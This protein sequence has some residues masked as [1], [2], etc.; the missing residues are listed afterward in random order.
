MTHSAGDPFSSDSFANDSQRGSVC[1]GVSAR[2]LPTQRGVS[3]QMGVYAQGVSAQRECLSRH[4]L[5]IIGQQTPPPP[6]PQDGHCHSRCASHPMQSCIFPTFIIKVNFQS[7]RIRFF[8][9]LKKKLPVA[10]KF[11][12]KLI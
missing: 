10:C 3:A 1:L 9:T 12:L 2:G 11:C 6:P 7:M 8:E 5:P 4:P